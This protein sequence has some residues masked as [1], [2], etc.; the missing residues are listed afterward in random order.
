[1]PNSKLKTGRKQPEK[2]MH[3]SPMNIP[4]KWLPLL[5]PPRR[6]NIEQTPQQLRFDTASSALRRPT[7]ALI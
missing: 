4:L 2:N 3:A 6:E 7:S 5:T 1:M